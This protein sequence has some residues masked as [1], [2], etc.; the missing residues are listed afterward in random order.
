MC[1]RRPLLIWALVF[2]SAISD[3]AA[4]TFELPSNGGQKCFYEGARKD[5]VMEATFRVIGNS[6]DRKLPP[7]DA[8][9]SSIQYAGWTLAA[10]G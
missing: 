9:V 5:T 2:M 8:E 7:I 10:S 1:H 3:C 6:Y 4:L